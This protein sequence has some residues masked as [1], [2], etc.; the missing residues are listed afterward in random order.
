MVVLKILGKMSVKNVYVDAVFYISIIS[1]CTFKRSLV[2]L[3]SIFFFQC[4]KQDF[5]KSERKQDLLHSYRRGSKE[6]KT[7]DFKFFDLK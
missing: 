2:Y 3:A 6:G 4:A 1:L 7:L 5:F